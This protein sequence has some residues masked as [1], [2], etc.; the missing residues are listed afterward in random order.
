M[1]RHAA[2][3]AGLDTL[4]CGCALRAARHPSGAALELRF[5]ALSRDDE[6]ER[7]TVRLLLDA[8]P[9]QIRVVEDSPPS[10]AR[11]GG[12]PLYVRRHLVG[13]RVRGVGALANGISIALD[14]HGEAVALRVDASAGQ[15]RVVDAG[16]ATLAVSRGRPTQKDD[17]AESPP[18]RPPVSAAERARALAQLGQAA[19]AAASQARLLQRRQ[20]DA[21]LRSARR[22]AARQQQDLDRAEGA[23]ALREAAEALKIALHRVPPGADRVVLPLPWFDPPREVEVPLQRDLSPQE[24]LSRLFRRARGLEAAQAGIVTRLAETESAI[25]ALAALR[26]AIEAGEHVTPEA[27]RKAGV[28]P[29]QGAPA[30]PPSKRAGAQKALPP[31]VD[32]FTTRSGRELLVGRSATANDALVTRLA[33]GDDLWFHVK[34]RRGA[35]GLLRGSRRDPPGG[36]ELEEAASLVAWLSGVQRDEAVDVSWTEAKHVRKGKALAAGMVYVR[37]ERVLRVVVRRETV[38]AFYARRE[39]T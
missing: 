6:G 25:A 24:N 22:K 7:P 38:D 17:P 29:P 19:D 2:L 23:D 5:E 1:S 4:L 8:Q 3:A 18:S 39:A 34:D 28:R 21:A 11:P 16:G 9:L 15:L 27:L 37:A 26:E 31:G 32:R 30:P 36:R 12:F 10:E 13:A 20:V 33:R 35:H 14:R